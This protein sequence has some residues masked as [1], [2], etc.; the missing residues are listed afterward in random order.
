MNKQ[1]IIVVVPVDDVGEKL[2][3]VD[4]RWVTQ[5]CYPRFTHIPR[6]A[7][8]GSK[9]SSTYPAGNSKPFLSK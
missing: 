1:K 8:A 3:N 2:V 6:R 7:Q 5:P 4:K 9:N